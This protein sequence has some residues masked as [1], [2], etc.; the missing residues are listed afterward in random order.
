MRGCSE[1]ARILITGAGGPAGL[2]LARQLRHHYL[3]GIDLADLSTS[4]AAGLFD[5]L[6]QAPRADDP[7]LIPFIT[8][9]AA[10]SEV[11][12][13]I[14]TVQD[15][16]PAIAAAV[17]LMGVPVVSSPSHGVAMGH[18]KLLTMRALDEAGVPVPKTRPGEDLA[19]WTPEL[20]FVLKPR[21]SRGGRGVQVIDTLDELE[22]LR[23]EG[24]PANQIVQEFADGEEY[25]V[26]VHVGR[27][28]RNHHVIPLRK[29]AL[30]QGRVGNAAAL[31]RCEATDV[32]DVSEVAWQAVMALGLRGPIDLDVR[33]M[34][35]GRPVVLEINAR[36]GANSEYAPELLE[37]VLAEFLSEVAP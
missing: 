28:P 37:K 31:E 33:R 8:Q 9:L 7:Q 25:A 32:P 30:K 27:V 4:E 29:T 16:L 22:A 26:Q 17:D 36:F 19:D 2:A 34:P 1:M 21:V 24:I 20:P 6:H 3:V 35:D 23:A 12:L 13:I 10:D 18:D 11:D 14:P 5:E 15:E